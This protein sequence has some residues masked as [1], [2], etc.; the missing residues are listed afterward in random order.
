MVPVAV[1]RAARRAGTLLT[2]RELEQVHACGRALCEVRV[3]APPPMA[4]L[5]G[6]LQELLGADAFASYSPER[7]TDGW[8]MAQLTWQGAGSDFDHVGVIQPLMNRFPENWAPVYDPDRPEPRQRNRVIRPMIGLS[9]DFVLQTPLF[10]KVHVPTRTQHFDQLRVLVCEGPALLA[11]V[12]GFREEPFT[13]REQ[14]RL[15][16][17]VPA[18]HKRLRIERRLRDAELYRAGLE[19]ALEALPVPAFVVRPNGAVAHAND[20]GRAA[21][22]VSLSAALAEGSADGYEATPIVVRG[23]P[24]AALIVRTAAPRDLPARLAEATTHWK[25]T[26]RQSEVLALVARGD[27]NKLI[28]A[29]LGCALRTVEVHVTALLC[30][31]GCDNRTELVARLARL[32]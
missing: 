2:P 32:A 28:A 25:L 17:L 7:A 5:G 3:G 12:G 21:Y 13:A 26:R 27:A 20:S 22:D 30:R 14:R 15:T 31:A 8:A 9:M 19:A 10:Q 18:L 1:E 24:A 6:A 4:E 23:E 29:K 11:W 16:A